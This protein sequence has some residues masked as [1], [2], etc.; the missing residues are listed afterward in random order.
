MI[1]VTVGAQMSFD[2]LI[3]WVDDWAVANSRSDLAAQIGPSDFAPKALEVI[4]FM[5]PQEFR[6][7]MVDATAVVAHAGMGTIIT[8]LELG[9][10]ILVVPRL[11]DLDETRNDHQV[12]TANRLA[13]DGLIL[14]AYNEHEFAEQMLLLEHQPERAKIAAQGS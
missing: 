3:G 8:A 10:P 1:F 12:A 4:P 5:D 9:K 13:E 6:R 11:G 7:R 14:A 2:R